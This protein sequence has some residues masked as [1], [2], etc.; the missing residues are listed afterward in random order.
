MQTGSKTLTAEEVAAKKKSYGLIPE[1]NYAT[2][3][4]EYEILGIEDF[5]GKKCYVVKLTNDNTIT[6]EYFEKETFQK[7]ASKMIVTEDG[8]TQ[9]VTYTYDN[10][11]EYSGFL[12]PDTIN[13][14]VGSMSLP[15]K[16]K[17]RVMNAKVDLEEFK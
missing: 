5:E 13:L 12:F 6:F 4:M 8:E 7:L 16:V 3:G 17:S 14:S 9:E 15:G 2:S 1:M 11:N 10:Y